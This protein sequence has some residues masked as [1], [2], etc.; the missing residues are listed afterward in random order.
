LFH[1]YFAARSSW[2]DHPSLPHSTACLPVFCVSYQD[3]HSTHAVLLACRKQLH[4]LVQHQF[5]DP[6][7]P[8]DS[9]LAQLAQTFQGPNASHI[10]VENAVFLL[11]IGHDS[12]ATA[13]AWLLWQLARH[14]H[15]VQKVRQHWRG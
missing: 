1:H 13:M 3:C 5:A 10:A 12:T 4:E 7:L 14:P 11:F 6:S 15:A 9:L 8:P 2:L